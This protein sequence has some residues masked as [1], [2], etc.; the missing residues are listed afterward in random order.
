MYRGKRIAIVCSD[1]GMRCAYSAGALYALAR[2]YGLQQ[3]DIAIATSGS[4]GSLLYYLT[5]QYEA[6]REIWTERLSTPRFI[7]FLRPT[8]IMDVDYLVD[9]VFKKQVPLQ[10][11]ALHSV[12]TQYSIPIT[13]IQTRAVR[14]ISNTDTVD[15][16]EVARAAKAI[17][18]FYGRNVRFE[19]NLYA[20]GAISIQFE[21]TLEK[22]RDLGAE[23]IIAIDTRSKRKRLR[24]L[25]AVKN[26]DVIVLTNNVLPS[27]LVTRNKKKIK[28]AFDL[29]Y[30]DT[31]DNRELQALFS[32]GN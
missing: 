8:K 32:K 5:G 22:A 3:P 30:Q 29:G 9:E 11:E 27:E 4:V 17:P 21:E 18:F 25:R 6:I 28:E 13:D 1:G 19:H 31:Q 20:D 23:V 24:L 15:I 16:F 7:S 26:S 14:Y 2:V 12:E 10:S